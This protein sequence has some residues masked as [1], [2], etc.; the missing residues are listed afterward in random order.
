[1]FPN[2]KVLEKLTRK[3]VSLVQPR[4]VILFGSAVRGEMN[5]N[6]DLDVLVVVRN[7]KHPRQITD[8][9]YLGTWILISR[10]ISS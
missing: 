9:I 10:W 8:K 3:I 4:R 6:S 2:D 5:E 1:M 7:G